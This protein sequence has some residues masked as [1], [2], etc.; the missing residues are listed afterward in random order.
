M[1]EIEDR[2]AVS[3]LHLARGKG[4]A[5]NLD[6][7]TAL[8]DALDR[9]ER[10]PARAA[11]ITGQ[12]KVFGAGVD[13]PALVDGGTDYI[14]RF[15]PKMLGTFERFAMFPKPMVAAVNGHAIA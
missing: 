10:S 2:G 8:A 15:V 3:V 4:N 7:V 11:V 1:I 6:L 14:R 12:G 5:L 9:L 13:L